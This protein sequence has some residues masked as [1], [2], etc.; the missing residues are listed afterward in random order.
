M[1]KYVSFTYFQFMI[2][3]CNT[4]YIFTPKIRS[5]IFCIKIFFTDN[6]E[7]NPGFFTLPNGQVQCPICQKCLSNMTVARTH[8]KS[9]HDDVKVN[10]QLCTR[11][12]KNAWYR[13]R[14]IKADHGI[15]PKG[16]DLKKI[17][18]YEETSGFLPLPN[19][20]AQC[21][22]CQKI[23]SNMTVAITHFKSVHDDVKVNC[24]ICKQS[25]KN[26]WY[27]DR[28]IK[29]DHGKSARGLDFETIKSEEIS[30]DEF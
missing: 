2:Y 15:S 6:N 30:E 25:Y 4:T 18:K 24:P 19:G 1:R 23:L 28:H 27:R 9:V 14:H 3:I 16:L 26:A 5:F 11:S 20:Q 17:I 22:K 8:Y 10:C 12:F 13:D 29:A 21:L 7:D